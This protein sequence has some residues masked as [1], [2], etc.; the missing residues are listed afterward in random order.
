MCGRFTLTTSREVLA[1]AFDLDDAPAL[2]PRFN[3]AP[4]QDVASVWQTPEGRR[5]LRPRRWG[6]VPHWARDARIGSRLV[7]ARAETAALKPAFRT[8][9]RQRRCLVPAD[10]FYEWKAV[11]GRRRKQPYYLRL[12]GGGLFAFAGLY[13]L[14]DAQ[15]GAPATCAIITTTPNDLVASIHNR[16]PVILEPADEGRWTDARVTDPATVLPCLR[17][18]P[19]GRMEGYPVSTLVSSP[20]NEGPRLVHPVS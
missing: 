12:K 11:P 2:T 9:L 15:A 3:V 20:G 7:N 8:A 16:M 19:A 17:P 13:T 14:A 6:L 1:R 4:G 10:G 18:L 5:E